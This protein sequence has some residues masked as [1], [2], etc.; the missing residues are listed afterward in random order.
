M[1]LILELITLFILLIMCM[2]IIGVSW[3]KQ[4]IK[5]YYKQLNREYN[6]DDSRDNE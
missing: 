6:D 2:A 1:M 5:H 4:K 3:E